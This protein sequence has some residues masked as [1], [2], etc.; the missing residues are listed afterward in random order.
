[1]NYE[2]GAK[3]RL[4]DGRVTFNAS[5]F[6][7]K[8]DGLQVIADAGTCSSRVIINADA[9][10]PGAELEL[11]VRPNES[12]GSRAFRRPRCRPKSPNH[13]SA[14]AATQSA[15]IRD[16]NQLPTSPE[17]QAVGTAALQLEHGLESRELPALH[18]CS[19]SAR[20]SRS[21]ATKSRTS[22][23][24]RAGGPPGSARLIDL[25]DVNVDQHRVRSGAALV[26]HRQPALGHQHG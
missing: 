24:S 19:T 16:G 8:I 3:T 18:A 10:T 15:G 4:A 5:V 23:S 9:E 22:G 12:L 17:L 2:L 25:G 26:R 20:R 14:P 13:S 6:V 11:F 7:T 21:W 1:M